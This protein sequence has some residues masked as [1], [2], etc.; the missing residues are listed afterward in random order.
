[1]TEPRKWFSVPAA[2]IYTGFARDTLLRALRS[3]ELA[4]DQ[5]AGRRGH[6]RIERDALD[7]WIRGEKAPVKVP[8]VTR[9]RSA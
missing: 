4:G 3:G 1:M 6:W 9:G 7:A 2:A 5:R 8:S